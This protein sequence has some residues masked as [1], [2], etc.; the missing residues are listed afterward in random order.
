M[1]ADKRTYV[2]ALNEA[3]CHWREIAWASRHLNDKEQHASAYRIAYGYFLNAAGIKS[4]TPPEEWL[5]DVSKQTDELDK[6]PYW[7]ALALSNLGWHLHYN[8]ELSE[9][10]R[11]VCDLIE[12]II[13]DEYLWQKD[14][15]APNL[16][17]EGGELMRWAVL[18]KTEMLR[19]HQYLRDRKL[20]EGTQRLEYIYQAAKHATLS[21]EYNYYMGRSTYDLRRAED[22]I[23]H[24]I[25]QSR[26]WEKE[27]FPAFYRGVTEFSKTLK[28]PTGRIR[29]QRML[30]ERFGPLGISTE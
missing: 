26:N 30:E 2:E 5:V 25:S 7:P 21:L 14:G 27:L 29:L 17:A 24:R 20:Y 9:R 22:N 4:K 23:S 8:G 19:C 1:Q 10:I 12:Q 18:G 16:R 15:S 3:G 28:T 11:F 6:S 13:G